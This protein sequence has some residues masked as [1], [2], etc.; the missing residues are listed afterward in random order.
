MFFFNLFFGVAALVMS[1]FTL[2][3][4]YQNPSKNNFFTDMKKSFT[5]TLKWGS[6]GKALYWA[7]GPLL[8]LFVSI[9]GGLAWTITAFLAYDNLKKK[10]ETKEQE[11][12]P[13]SAE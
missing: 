1:A 8:L 2:I 10:Q 12:A 11:E 4:I 5:R 6:F 3:G 13:S 9:W 7:T